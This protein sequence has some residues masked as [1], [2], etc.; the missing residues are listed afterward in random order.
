MAKTSDWWNTTAGQELLRLAMAEAQ[1]PAA[2]VVPTDS[3]IGYSGN[4]GKAN[5]LD[6][7]TRDDLD[8]AVGTISSDAKSLIDQYLRK[9]ATAGLTRTGRSASAA[10]SESKMRLEALRELAGQ[11]SNRVSKGLDYLNDVYGAREKA[12]TDSKKAVAAYNQALID[13]QANQAKNL[14]DIYK[15]QRSDWEADLSAAQEA[16]KTAYDRA[17]QEI[18]NRLEN[19]KADEE[20][21][22]KRKNQYDWE[23]LMKKASLIDSV[24]RFGAGWTSADDYLL[25]R[26][27]KK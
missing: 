14:T 11:S 7:Q 19:Q 23:M 24:G 6:W 17:Q 22:A 2:P 16:E 13:W 9:M 10:N 5:L 3:E 8:R 25:K 4:Y 18:K 27:G 26:L 15:M 20:S 21:Y 12:K 1:K